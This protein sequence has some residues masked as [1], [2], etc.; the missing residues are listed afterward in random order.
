M[1]QG[2]NFELKSRQV[3]KDLIYF[4]EQLED[5]MPEQEW[6]VRWIAICTLAR[7]VGHILKEDGKR[8]CKPAITDQLF[9]EIKSEQIFSDFIERD[10]NLILKEY[11]FRTENGPVSIA[12]L[13]T[14]AGDRIVT[15]Q[16]FHTL[17]GT[18]FDG[19]MPKAA[20]AKVC[21]WWAEKLDIVER[22][23]ADSSLSG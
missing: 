2:L 3:L 10:R 22:R 4:C 13:L 1:S 16:N 18:C 5:D 7:A 21:E 17:K 19:M 15:S 12:G 23:M 14:E 9:Q 20:M 6:R 8:L 11:N